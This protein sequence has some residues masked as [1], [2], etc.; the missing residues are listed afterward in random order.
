MSAEAIE[1]P[2][3]GW[4]FRGEDEEPSFILDLVSAVL[5]PLLLHGRLKRQRKDSESSAFKFGE[6]VVS[7]FTAVPPTAP[8]PTTNEPARPSSFISC[9]TVS[10]SISVDVVPASSSRPFTSSALY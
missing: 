3:A 7:R 10:S 2:G 5:L 1:K 9:L 4:L 6:G 8:R